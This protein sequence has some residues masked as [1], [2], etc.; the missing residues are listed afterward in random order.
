[1]ATV[2]TIEAS[3]GRQAMGDVRPAKRGKKALALAKLGRFGG[4]ASMLRPYGRL[5]DLSSPA[6][7]A[8]SRLAAVAVVALCALASA[9]GPA[10]QAPPTP[11]L[12]VFDGGVLESDPARYRL[13]KQDVSATQLSIASFLVV[14]ARGV[15]LWDT[16]AVP[17]GE[18]TPPAC[19]SSIG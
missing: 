7:L 8:A 16:G 14:H 4:F 1:M 11:R 18:W 9:P 6:S 2:A 15:L 19:R 12:Y 10:A 3:F 13:T 17:D 5:P